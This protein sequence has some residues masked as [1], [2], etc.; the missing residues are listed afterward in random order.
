MKL[1]AILPA[2][3]LADHFEDPAVQDRA[4]QRA[5]QAA[6][7]INWI[8]ER[9]LVPEL[10]SHDE[11]EGEE[12]DEEFAGNYRMERPHVNFWLDFS[13]KRLL[14]FRQH[15]NKYQTARNML[16]TSD[17]AWSAKKYGGD[18]EEFNERNKIYHFYQQSHLER[19]SRPTRN[20][21]L[22][23]IAS[24]ENM[25][26]YMQNGVTD[27]KNYRKPFG[28]YFDYGCHCFPGSF[29]DPKHSP[30]AAPVDDIDRACREHS[31]AYDCAKQDF[32]ADC[33]GKYQAYSW[34]GMIGKDGMTP[35]IYCVDDANTN[36]CSWA[37]CEADKHLAERLRDLLAEY[38]IT[39]Q[40]ALDGEMQRFDRE[41]ICQ[42]TVMHE[43]TRSEHNENEN[44]YLNNGSNDDSS[45]SPANPAT[46][47]STEESASSSNEPVDNTPVNTGDFDNEPVA[48]DSG[49]PASPGSLEAGR[50]FSSQSPSN[51]EE[52]VSF[53]PGPST[54]NIPKY[55]EGFPQPEYETI[56][57]A[58]RG[59][60]ID[61]EWPVP[62][63][64]IDPTSDEYVNTDTGLNI[65]GPGGNFNPVDNSLNFAEEI[66]TTAA[67]NYSPAS[68]SQPETYEELDAE[69]DNVQE[70]IPSG[71]IISQ[72]SPAML[73]D[74]ASAY[75]D[76]ELPIGDG[77]Y[78]NA[79]IKT[80]GSPAG[81]DSS[82]TPDE[83]TPEIVLKAAVTY[84]VKQCCG[85]YP[86][87]YKYSA[88]KMGCCND[89]GL[90]TLY[91][92]H[93]AKCCVVKTA[94]GVQGT[95][96]ASFLAKK[97]D[98]CSFI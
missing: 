77:E 96:Y 33:R 20:S 35:E 11:L 63:A 52:S 7:R 69:L 39:N 51:E 23:R 94:R 75:P 42:M 10:V 98:D 1:I 24:L 86:K 41:N 97:D 8:T 49:A 82:T 62:E 36:P 13:N 38:Q 19:Q 14:S 54:I 16:G 95:T 31:W 26:Q 53:L 68:T 84:S 18:Q 79:E 87:R 29:M 9:R 72:G 47:G 22:R 80:G 37:I 15:T 3:A 17:R 73:G 30:H 6:S 4:Y 55:Q 56:P 21:L 60:W 2:M 44:I 46:E 67:P 70:N 34:E 45:N 28:A 12:V 43:G 76:E 88:N 25:I 93:Y 5:T 50:Q 40:V 90:E 32:G 66:P 58:Q 57:L 59:S 78:L 83:E 89:N 61:M 71:E 27:L 65:S 74:D 92:P 81:G 91:S 48:P 64:W 85:Q